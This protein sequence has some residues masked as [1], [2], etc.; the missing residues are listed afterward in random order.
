M[1]HTA[2]VFGVVPSSRVKCAKISPSAGSPLSDANIML[3]SSSCSGVSAVE[4]D[5]ERVCT[6]PR[7]WPAGVCSPRSPWCPRVASYSSVP[8]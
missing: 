3:A 8:P 6:L 1:S 5:V 4:R 2:P 7:F